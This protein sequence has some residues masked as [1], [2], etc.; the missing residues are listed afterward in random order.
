[1][2]KII[3][4]AVIVC[5]MASFGANA[6]AEETPDSQATETQISASDLGTSDQ[7]LLPN[8]PFYFLKE[9]SRGVQ[10]FFAFGQ[11]KKTELEQ[12]FSN[13]RL[14]E[15]K[16]LVE[17]GKASPDILKKAT[18]KYEQ[19]MAKIKERADTIKEKASKDENVNKFLEKFTNQQVLHEKILQKLEGQVPKDVLQKIKD[20]RE[21]HLERFK[22]VMTKLEDNKEKVA[23][24]IK[25][26]LQNGDSNN[27]EVLE[28]IKNKMPDNVKEKLEGIKENVREKV[29]DKLIEK[30]TEKNGEKNCPAVTKPVADFCKGGIVK[31]ERDSKECAIN[32]S[33]KIFPANGQKICTTDSDCPQI[34]SPC[35]QKDDG[36][37]SANGSKSGRHG[38]SYNIN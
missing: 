31:V 14:L 26:A 19:T 6:V 23:E 1:M 29:N 24:K 8:N 11:L 18:E 30:A 12:K 3:L 17:E 28:R 34:M 38:N 32:F 20:A 37:A 9:W 13:E 21:K 7:N 2:K 25:N 35:I 27:P 15:L 4:I 5:L 22:E 10:S 36:T 33:C 16:K